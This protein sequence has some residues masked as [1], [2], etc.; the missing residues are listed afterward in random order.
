[1]P[2]LPDGIVEDL[3][4]GIMKGIMKDLLEDLLKELVLISYEAVILSDQ[5]SLNACK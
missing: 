4:K 5:F 2:R 1:M 3:L